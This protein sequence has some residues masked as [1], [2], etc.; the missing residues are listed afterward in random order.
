MASENIAETSSQLKPIEQST[1]TQET[2]S[3]TQVLARNTAVNVGAAYAVKFASM[4]FSIYVVRSL[5]DT[6]YGKYATI[7]ALVGML[8]MVAEMGVTSYGIR[9]IAKD[10]SRTTAI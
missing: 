5:G 2:K 10:R 8:S 6:T 4:I 1:E 7:L 9:E 3:F